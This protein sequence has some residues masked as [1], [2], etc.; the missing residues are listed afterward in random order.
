MAKI[1]VGVNGYGTIGKRVATAVS[2]QAD[3]EVIGITKTR[4]TFEAKTA[5]AAGRPIYVPAESI[6]AFEKAGIAVA[7]T[8]DDMIA[9]ADVIVDCTPGN[10]GPE[11]KEKYQKAGKKAIF[12]GGEEHGLTGVSF[13]STA[14]YKDSW[15]M[16]F[17]RVVSCN[18][19]GLLRTLSLLDRAYKIQ[20]AYVTI[21]RRAADPGDS[22]TGPV[23]GLEPSVSLPTHHGVD[24]KSVLPWIDIT[25]MAIK[26]STTLM[27]IQAVVVKLGK[28]VSTDEVLDLFAKAP[29]VRLVSSKDG[30][31]STN[32]VM[33][34]ARELGRDRSDMYEI[35]IWSD[36]VKVVGDTLY[37]YQAVHQ[38][39]DVIPEN[40]DCIRSM[41]KLMEGPE[42]VAKTNK[43]LG[44]DH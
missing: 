19:T 4:P 30:I 24:V 26:A 9:A 14:N 37:Y 5:A 6:P 17:S 40:V 25:T 28:E 2:K 12:Q 1:K 32:Q 11:Y 38:E 18:T 20:N 31:K 16:Q 42:S 22:K 39:A 3:M 34:L 13:N 21:V 41:C 27:H 15:G 44:I 10:V 43:A 29:R 7:G 8:V 23:N 36:G 33:E 35:C